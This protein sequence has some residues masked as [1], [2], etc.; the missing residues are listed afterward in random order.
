MTKIGVQGTVL[1]IRALSTARHWISVRPDAAPEPADW[2]CRWMDIKCARSMDMA[3]DRLDLLRR[4][5]SL[6]ELQAAA[7]V[8]PKRKGEN[9]P[10]A[11]RL[12]D[13]DGD[14]MRCDAVRT[15]HGA[16]IRLRATTAQCTAERAG[17]VGDGADGSVSV[18]PTDADA[19]GHHGI[20]WRPSAVSC[21]RGGPAPDV[22][23]DSCQYD[24]PAGLHALLPGH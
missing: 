23:A 15:V 19:R 14:V 20:Q 8:V 16:P 2:Y 4:S 6:A 1:F 3:M 13:G 7:A 22:A 9:V 5:R 10:V 11:T 12:S 21:A 18:V 17:Y 24:M